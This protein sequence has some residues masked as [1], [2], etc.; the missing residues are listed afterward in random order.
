MTEDVLVISAGHTTHSPSRL[1][2]GCHLDA[3]YGHQLQALSSQLLSDGSFESEQSN[4]SS[5]LLSPWQHGGGGGIRLDAEYRMHGLKSMRITARQ[6]VSP[7]W[8][9]NR[10]PFGHGLFLEVGRQY[11]LSFHA[12][13]HGGVS[14]LVLV[15]LVDWHTNRTV[16][17]ATLNI[18]APA[19]RRYTVE[20]PPIAAGTT[21]DT[22]GRC[23]GELRLGSTSRGAADVSIDYVRL[24]PG[25]WG[26]YKGLPVLASGVRA[27]EALGIGGIR[28]GGSFVSGPNNT[29][30]QWRRWVGPAWRRPSA[31]DACWPR[32]VPPHWHPA[33][34]VDLHAFGPFELLALAD[35][36]GVEAV[37]TTSAATPPSVLADLV[38]YALGDASTSALARQRVADF[39]REPPYPLRYIEL[40]NEEL[41]GQFVPQAAA[42]EARA[43]S[44]GLG[45]RLRY[46]WAA[47]GP[48]TDSF[49]PPDALRAAVALS[50]RIDASL[51][52]SVHIGHGY[53]GY[54]GGGA[55]GLARSLFADPA[56]RGF[57]PFGVANT[58]TNAKRQD[59]GR[60]LMEGGDLNEW[61]S[62][63]DVAPRLHGRY[64][65]FCVER[66]PP[67]TDDLGFTQ[68]LVS[69]LPNATW[70]QPPGHVHAMVRES[71]QP[72]AVPVRW[73]VASS[74]DGG[75]AASLDAAASHNVGG[76]VGRRQHA[77]PDAWQQQ[78]QKW[79]G[80]KT[81][82]AARS[83]DGRRLVLRLTSRADRPIRVRLEVQGENGG[84]GGGGG[85][86]GGGGAWANATYTA[87][88]LS[89]P[90]LRAINTAA[91]PMAVAPVRRPSASV[92][93]ALGL[94]AE[95]FA[96]V[97]VLR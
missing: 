81:A 22:D 34:C 80:T 35:A 44:L 13:A 69:F 96:V 29:E 75:A 58:E 88:I 6:G 17:L 12:S 23:G 65:S 76:H 31:A 95:S 28:F 57:G 67:H 59:M 66:A 73:A 72:L 36:M 46:L 5:S 3:G 52:A 93:E 78:Q 33:W 86:R 40:G 60:A 11:E 49:L 37:L 9:A 41:N 56:Y 39:G 19:W 71:W 4:S 77:T 43:R 64:A 70:L 42:M 51:A 82:S 25:A 92:R 79:N 89:A 87:T 48:T 15:G 27:L 32:W 26:R 50:P 7:S 20:L 91:R 18:S 68:G 30:L 53:D 54:L 84:G 74:P 21:C 90:S 10:G 45:G 63:D 94:P 55:V 61:L 16:S 24:E 1:V 8:I 83:A 14:S 47:P 62:A 38:E 2:L 97:E 85:G